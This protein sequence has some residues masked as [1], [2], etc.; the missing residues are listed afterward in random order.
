M[1]VTVTTTEPHHFGGEKHVV[2]CSHLFGNHIKNVKEATK[3]WLIVEEEKKDEGR[4]DVT[5]RKER[6]SLAKM[7]A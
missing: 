3:T 5:S 1:P 2:G 4:Y 6:K 7:G